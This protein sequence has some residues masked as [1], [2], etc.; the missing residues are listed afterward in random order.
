MT[1]GIEKSLY[2][3]KR[4]N[5]IRVILYYWLKSKK[6]DKMANQFLQFISDE[7]LISAI[8]RLYN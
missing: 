2:K 1:E 3:L 8:E 5:Y 4:V 7:N 6:Q